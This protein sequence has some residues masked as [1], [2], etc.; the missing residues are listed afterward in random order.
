MS[1]QDPR[2]S[3]NP[4]ITFSPPITTDGLE[5][6]TLA[7]QGNILS[8]TTGA[9]VGGNLYVYKISQTSPTTF[10]AQRIC[11]STG[12]VNQ[13]PG[14]ADA[15]I[16]NK[17]LFTTDQITTLPDGPAGVWVWDLM[18][19]TVTGHWDTPTGQRPT[20][21]L[22]TGGSMVYVGAGDGV[23]TFNPNNATGGQTQSVFGTYVGDP[24]G[25]AAVTYPAAVASI[26][27]TLFIGPKL[28]GS[29]TIL[30]CNQLNQTA[31]KDTLI[32]PDDIGTLKAIPNSPYIVTPENL[33][34]WDSATETLTQIATLPIPGLGPAIG[35]G[36][37]WF[38]PAANTTLQ[39]TVLQYDVASGVLG[40]RY[41]A[42]DDVNKK[43]SAVAVMG[44]LLITGSQDGIVRA[45]AIENPNPVTTT[46]ATTTATASP[47]TITSTVLVTPT[48]DFNMSSEA[49][50]LYVDQEVSTARTKVGVGVAVPLS[51][52][53]ILLACGL[54]Y[55]LHRWRN[56]RGRSSA[57]TNVKDKIVKDEKS[58]APAIPATIAAAEQAPHEEIA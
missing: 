5:V 33:Y 34:A 26:G 42:T 27:T 45:Y 47:L 24:L 37:V 36:P 31:C 20:Y 44:N 50:K 40:R 11:Q 56:E 58:G 21:S 15:F 9:T 16:Y 19:C 55:V 4:P 32:A 6:T 14:A 8:I 1:A 46:T 57:N 2:P 38:W 12:S 10:T 17:M 43:A 28:P 52:V 35:I 3:T 7:T 29:G 23:Y 48:T 13:K 49:F 54:V 41:A 51:V 39:N 22:A 53:C 30:A 25:T 18:S